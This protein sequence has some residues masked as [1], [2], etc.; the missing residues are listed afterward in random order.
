VTI[1]PAS[2][3]P[4][5]GFA[6]ITATVSEKLHGQ[7]NVAVVATGSAPALRVSTHPVPRSVWV[8][9]LR[10]MYERHCAAIGVE[11]RVIEYPPARGQ[12]AL[13]PAGPA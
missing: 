10:P 12:A 1:P 4:R 5:R 7:V 3:R 9:L 11:L 6:L 2:P 8:A 13:S